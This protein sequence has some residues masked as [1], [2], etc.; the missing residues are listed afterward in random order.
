MKTHTIDIL[1]PLMAGHWLIEPQGMVTLANDIARHREAMA[2]DVELDDLFALR[3]APALMAYKDDDEQKQVGVMHVQGPMLNGAPP[4]YEKLGM[5]TSYKTIAAEARALVEAGAS[6]IVIN[7]DTP[8][9]SV[10]GCPECG[11]ALNNLG[12][13]VVAYA[14][15]MMTSGGYW[16]A[17]G[18]DAIM[19]SRSANVGSIGVIMSWMD[20]SR[21]LAAVGIEARTITNEG[22]VQKSAMHGG[23]AT[24]DAQ[25]RF[26]QER[27]DEMGAQFRA[28]VEDGR[29]NATLDP[30]VW[31]AGYYSA[32]TAWGLGL[33]DYIGTLDDAITTAA[34]IG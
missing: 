22:A 17:S 26:L 7:Y 13:P 21:M 1:A 4:V 24:T 20:V 14:G 34:R 3:P 10:A 9:G 8:G 12:V 15:G 6:A 23:G 19:A 11:D 16:L 27:I 31:E 30:V 28:Q 18:A 5:L 33:V 32:E 2:L 29:K 25:D